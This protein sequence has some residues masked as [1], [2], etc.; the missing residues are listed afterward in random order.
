MFRWIRS[1]VLWSM[2]IW[3]GGR[4][5]LR[6]ENSKARGRYWCRESL[7]P[8]PSRPQLGC[9]VWRSFWPCRTSWRRTWSSCS[10]HTR[11]RTRCFRRWTLTWG[12]PGI[13]SCHLNTQGR[14]EQQ[15]AGAE[16]QRWVRYPGRFRLTFG[17]QK[18]VQ[19]VG[20]LGH[21]LGTKPAK[22]VVNRKWASFG[23]RADVYMFRNAFTYPSVTGAWHD[24]SRDLRLHLLGNPWGKNKKHY[25]CVLLTLLVKHQP[26]DQP[27][28]QAYLSFSLF[29]LTPSMAGGCSSLSGE[30]TS[31]SMDATLCDSVPSGSVAVWSEP[32]RRRFICVLCVI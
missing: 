25:R 14:C 4:K 11:A 32:T 21:L 7:C 23:D 24:L 5:P 28:N 26:T 31:L 8:P 22:D 18:S 6:A 19:R 2:L 20:P 16:A 12:R 30:V 13:S 10:P 27:T 15:A 29:L 1:L 17:R 9:S 3:E